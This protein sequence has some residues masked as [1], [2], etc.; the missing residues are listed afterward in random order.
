MAMHDYAVAL[1]C[2]S[3]LDVNQR[4]V[5]RDG[6][7][8]TT[9]KSAQML[10]EVLTKRRAEVLEPLFT[11]GLGKDGEGGWEPSVS[12][13]IFVTVR[14]PFSCIFGWGLRDEG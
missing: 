5:S 11:S 10:R 3:N 1:W 7:R 9:E 4:G 2:R 14:H 8:Q 6:R 12:P 13:F